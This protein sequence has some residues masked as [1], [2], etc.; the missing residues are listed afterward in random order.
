MTKRT[1]VRGAKGTL[2]TAVAALSCRSLW[3]SLR[4]WAQEVSA[5]APDGM[6]AGTLESLLAGVVGVLAMPVL[7]WA[8]MRVLGERGTAL[9]VLGGAVAWP[10]VGG[11]VVEDA[12][13]G[14]ETAGFL[15]LFTALGGLLSL[16]RVP[17]GRQGPPAS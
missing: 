8:G 2:V 10:F 3:A 1:A 14:A 6:F 5:A 15:V 4:A 13:G 16:A 11:H 12:A 7:L 17:G 9:L